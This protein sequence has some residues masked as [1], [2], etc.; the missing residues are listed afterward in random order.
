MD[1]TGIRD[2]RHSVLR[3]AVWKKP[4]LQI[5]ALYSKLNVNFNF[6]ELSSIFD[7]IDNTI[8]DVFVRFCCVKGFFIKLVVHWFRRPSRSMPTLK[9]QTRLYSCPVPLSPLLAA[10]QHNI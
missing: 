6:A 4:I 10:N 5:F 7:I 3:M 1:K 9:V 2:L 8:F